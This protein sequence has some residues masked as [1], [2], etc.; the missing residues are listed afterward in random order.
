M[1]LG[2][3]LSLALNNRILTGSKRSERIRALA[4][5]LPAHEENPD[6]SEGERESREKPT[7]PVPMKAPFPND[8]YRPDN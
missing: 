3:N 7:G 6:D 8:Q 5:N 4:E 1:A 2:E